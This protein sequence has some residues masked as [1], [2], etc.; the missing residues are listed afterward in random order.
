MARESKADR[1][2]RVHAEA[3]RKFQRDYEATYDDRMESLSD[4]RF[5]SIAGAQWEGPLAEQFEY[6]PKF[7]VNKI[8]SAI[9]RIIGEMRANRI[10]AKFVPRGDDK[11]AD[12]RADLLAKLM[13]A[14]EQDSVADEAYDNSF[15][16]AVGGGMGAFRLRA[17]V[18]DDDYDDEEEGEEPRQRICIEPINDADTSVFFDINAQRL[19]KSDAKHCTV[20][21]PMTTAAYIETYDDNPASWPSTISLAWYDRSAADF[22]RIAEYYEVE[23]RR[24]VR[25]VFKLIDGSE[26]THVDDELDDDDGA[27]RERLDATG[28]VEVRQIKNKKRRR[29]HKWILSGSRVLKDCGFVAGP[30]IPVVPVYGK[31]WFVDGKERWMGHVR[32]AKDPQRIKNM[33]L[34]KLAE[35]ASL[36]V[37]EIPMFAPEQMAGHEVI[38]R[39]ANIKNLSWLPVNPITD[40]NGNPQTAGPLGYIKPPSIPPALAALM[41]ISEQDMLDI[42]GNQQQGD[43]MVSNIS[44][45]VVAAVQM[46]VDTQTSIYLSNYAKARQRGATIYRDMA[47]EIYVEENRRMKGIEANGKASMHTVNVPIVDDD[48]AMGYKNDMSDADFDVSVEVG[49]SS[50]SKRNAMVRTLIKMMATTQDQETLGVLTALAMQNVEGEGMAEVRDFFRMKSIRAGVIKPNEEEQKA[51]AAEQQQKGQAPPDAQTQYLQS[52]AVEAEAK[53][54]KARADTILTIANAEKT[55]AQTENIKVDTL[56]DVGAAEA[57][58]LEAVNGGQTPPRMGG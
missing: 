40:V 9:I 30:N 5:Y 49:P 31:R 11:D 25:H 38:W 20:L 6:R 16:E 53:A 55:K 12:E 36:S 21:R 56:L 13:R 17:E 50:Q 4:R 1:E 34:S 37:N 46:H 19:D 15:E 8:S 33:Q 51:L 10:D 29:I 47:S 7:E 26:V 54:A 32:L 23:M 43:K 42:L 48:G 3:L 44:E 58:M 57:A 2:I 28:A 52:A 41:Q 35:I 27:L 18:N 14:D 24:E 39:D 22:V 45:E